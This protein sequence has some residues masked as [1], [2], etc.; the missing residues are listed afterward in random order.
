MMKSL[1]NARLAARKAWAGRARFATSPLG[2]EHKLRAE[3]MAGINWNNYLGPIMVSYPVV[4]AVLAAS[5]G[6]VNPLTG[7]PDEWDE[8]SAWPPADF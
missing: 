1:M 5:I 7:I 4:A 2:N 3:N 6:G 8:N